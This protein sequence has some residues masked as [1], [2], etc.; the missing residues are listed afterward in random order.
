MAGLLMQIKAFG[1]TLVLGII[2]GGIFQYYQLTVRSARPGKYSLYLLDF[3]LWIFLIMV[4]FI[5]MLLINQGEMRIYVFLALIAG[6]FIYYRYLWQRLLQPLSQA[7]QNT[8]AGLDAMFNML[9]KPIILIKNY[10]KEH[11][12]SP[13]PSDPED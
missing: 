8:A 9:N 1:L 12:K 2:T 3:I 13:P 10:I 7:G 11:K 6:V 5:S 4:V